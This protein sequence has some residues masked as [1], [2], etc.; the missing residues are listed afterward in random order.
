MLIEI[1]GRD[2]HGGSVLH[3]RTKIDPTALIAVAQ[4]KNVEGKPQ[5][6]FEDAIATFGAK[7]A[8]LAR[9]G[10][11]GDEVD[12]TAIQI[13]LASWFL[14]SRFRN[15]TEDDFVRSTI[16]INASQNVVAYRLRN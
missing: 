2:S 5:K 10:V 15:C 13:A 14:E 7:I 3:G 9:D 11:I 6:Y 1:I 16:E 8:G 4:T 12:T